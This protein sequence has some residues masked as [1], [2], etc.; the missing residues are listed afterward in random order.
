MTTATLLDEQL[1]LV[2]AALMPS[3]AL[4]C[5]VMLHTGLRISDVLAL[6]SEPLHRTPCR[7]WVTEKKTGKR[8]FIGLPRELADAILDQAND[9]WAFPGDGTGR[10]RTRQAV[11]ADI[12]HCQYALRLNVNLGSHSMRKAYAVQLMHDYGD[13]KKVQKALNH[14]SPTTTMLYAMADQLLQNEKKKGGKYRLQKRS[15]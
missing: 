9:T 12:K 13:I 7:F 6:P 8:K 1:E 4:V 14:S 3:N 10:P 2:L 11:W 15:P 5:K